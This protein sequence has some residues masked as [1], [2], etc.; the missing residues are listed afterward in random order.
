M[1]AA[2]TSTT[3]M[4]SSTSDYA[5]LRASVRDQVRLTR[6][7]IADPDVRVRDAGRGAAYAERGADVAG[8]PVVDRDTGATADDDPV[9]IANGLR[10]PESRRVVRFLAGRD[11][12]HRRLELR[13]ERALLRVPEVRQRDRRKH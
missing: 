7:G 8:I 12:A 11:V 3:A 4:P 1:I 6:T 2:A 13:V 5:K 10:I 9:E